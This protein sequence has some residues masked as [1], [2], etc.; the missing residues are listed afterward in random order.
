MGSHNYQFSP[1]AF[2]E[3]KLQYSYTRAGFFTNDPFGPEINIEGFGFFGR[4]IFLPSENIERHYDI[5]DNFSKIFG[6]HTLKFGGSMFFN[7][8]T[9]T[10][11]TFF[12]G[13]FNFGAAIP[14]GT[15]IA[16]NPAL[17]PAVLTQLS[18]APAGQPAAESGGAD[19][20]AAGVQSE[21]ADRLPAGIRRRL[22]RIVD[23]PLRPIRPGR[24]EAEA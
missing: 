18:G 16:L 20:L 2:N 7:R 17:G 12:G 11:E 9:T 14:L 19:Q 23:E 21:P 10:S 1:T 15:I 24:L 6:D 5:Y 8:L 13:R 22:G 4:D 3:L